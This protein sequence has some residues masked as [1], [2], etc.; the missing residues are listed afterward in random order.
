LSSAL[1]A[2]GKDYLTLNK[3][4]ETVTAL[5]QA[6]ALAHLLFALNGGSHFHPGKSGSRIYRG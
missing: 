5:T 4:P 6:A 1:D 2:L 3:T